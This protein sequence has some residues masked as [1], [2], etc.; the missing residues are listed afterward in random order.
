MQKETFLRLCVCADASVFVYMALCMLREHKAAANAKNAL[1][2][3][4]TFSL[5]LDPPQG[6]LVIKMKV[7]SHLNAKKQRGAHL[8]QKAQKSLINSEH[9]RSCRFDYFRSL[10]SL[11]F[12]NNL[13]P[14]N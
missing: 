3:A 6:K 7:P 14:M 10:S 1:F 8:S 13:W 2:R 12:N 4:P 9:P 5:S 11:I